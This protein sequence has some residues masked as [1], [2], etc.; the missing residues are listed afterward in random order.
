[1]NECQLSFLALH[2][3]KTEMNIRI[4][5]FSGLLLVACSTEG[6]KKGDKE[7]IETPEIVD[8]LEMQLPV[9]EELKFENGIEITWLEKSN[10]EAIKDGDLVM[11]DYKVRLKDSTIIDGNHLLNLDNFPFMVGFGMQPR[12]WDIAFRHLKVGDFARIKL[13]AKYARGDKGVK[14]LI[15]DNADNFLTVRIISKKKPDK[16]IDGTKVWLLKQSKKSK[17]SFGEENSI[18]FHTI[19]CSP[20][21]PYYYNSF[22]SNL[23]FEMRL[24]DNGVIPGL[25][26]A[27]INAKRGDRLFIVVPASEAYGS[28]GYLDIVKPNESLFYNLLVLDV[29]E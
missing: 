7:V 11:I 1:M 6:V 24:S 23:P 8:S 21:S 18:L 25:K 22:A 19:I 29:L 16:T 3:K 26:K 17:L 4:L 9:V 15:P 12:G 27:L 5:F 13:P 28:K 2:F 14:N 20:S 10:G